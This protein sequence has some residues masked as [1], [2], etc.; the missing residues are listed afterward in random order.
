MQAF[1]DPVQGTQGGKFRDQDGAAPGVSGRPEQPRQAGV[2]P[3]ALKDRGLGVT[4]PAVEGE[5][6]DLMAAIEEAPVHGL[7]VS[8]AEGGGGGG[9]GGLD[10]DVLEE[11]LPKAWRWLSSN[12]RRGGSNSL[13]LHGSGRARVQHVAA[14]CA[15]DDM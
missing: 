12:R 11:N 1:D 9:G 8:R 5:D 6:S 14:Q 13:L 10:L 15:R 4:G 7:G 2:A 3:E